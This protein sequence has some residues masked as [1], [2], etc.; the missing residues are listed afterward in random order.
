[1]QLDKKANQSL[2]FEKD[3]YKTLTLP[4]ETTLDP[5][6]WGNIILG[7]L[8]G[9]TTDAISGAVNQYSPGQYNITLQPLGHVQPIAVQPKVVQPAPVPPKAIQPATVQPTVV[10]PAAIEKNDAKTFIIANYKNIL[11]ELY[12]GQG[13][14][15]SALMTLLK[16]ERQNQTK[17]IN[18]IKDLA[19]QYKDI[20]TFA[21]KV[22]STF[23]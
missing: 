2:V 4:L 12:T 22:V 5:W 10:Q 7:G 20:P 18:M 14:Y 11:P 21:D 9:S 15:V 8:F 19:E 23:Y 1:M 13:Q 6:F 17:A 3:G 16:V